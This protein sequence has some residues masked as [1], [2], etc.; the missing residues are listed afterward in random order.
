VIKTEN[1]LSHS[2]KR[3]H[4]LM[5]QTINQRLLELDLTTAQGHA[6]GYIRCAK[7]PPCARDIETAFGLSHA[8]VSGIL[9]RLESKGFIELRPD[10]DDRRVK[11]IHLLQRG[12]NSTEQIRSHILDTENAMAEGFSPQELAQFRSFL[13]RAISNLSP[14]PNRE[15]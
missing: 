2:F 1:L 8:T 9:S 14:P 5:E 4:F 15:E 13:S 7:E 10:E 6:I 3:L 11:R 12:L